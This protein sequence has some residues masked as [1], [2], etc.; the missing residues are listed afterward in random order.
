[1]TSI[2]R[3]FAF[4]TSHHSRRSPGLLITSRTHQTF[5]TD[6]PT[7]PIASQHRSAALNTAT[8]VALERLIPALACKGREK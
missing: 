5:T 8:C 1:M 4:S 3:T 6:Y 7:S 2:P